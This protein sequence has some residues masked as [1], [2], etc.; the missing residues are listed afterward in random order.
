MTGT[1]SATDIQSIPSMKLT[2]FTSHT[3]PKAIATRSA[4][5]GAAGTTRR[6]AGR[7]ATTS[8]TASAWN[9]KREPARIGRMSS[10]IPSA[11]NPTV[12]ATTASR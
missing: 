10:V 4:T 2:R 11:A 8:P 7:V 5:N 1:I 12:A 3:S 9:A 6:S